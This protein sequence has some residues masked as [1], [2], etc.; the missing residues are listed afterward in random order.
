MG[1]A[2][3]D[4]GVD[5]E[6]SP[7][8]P[9]SVTETRTPGGLGVTEVVTGNSAEELVARMEEEDE[10]KFVIDEGKMAEDKME[11][12]EALLSLGESSRSPGHQEKPMITLMPAHSPDT[13]E[14]YH[15]E[16][17]LISSS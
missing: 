17:N 12:V 15:D 7:S 1:D 6:L 5:S 10:E 3:T 9:D 11:T 4:S 2:M 16:A 8:S 14:N 13:G